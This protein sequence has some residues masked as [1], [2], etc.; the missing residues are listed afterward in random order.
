M[1]DFHILIAPNAFKNSLTAQ[2]AAKAIEKGFQRSALVCTTECFPIGDG[3]DGTGDLLIEKN[4]GQV[5]D[6]FVT[7][8]LGRKIKASYG[9]IDKG[10]T[11]V[12]E[13]AQASGL[14]LLET[15]EL[16]PLRATSFG[17]GQVISDALSNNVSKI[18]IAMGGSAT[19]DGGT[20]ILIALG[21]RFLDKNGV[22]LTAIENFNSLHTIDTSLIDPRALACEIIVLCDVDNRLLGA[23]GAAAM[24]GPQKGAGKE[25]VIKLENSLTRLTEIIK[26]TN[27]KNI[28][29][30]PY[31]GTAG[32][33]AAGLYALV[34]AQL[35]NGAES[36]LHFTGFEK[37]LAVSNLVITGEGSIDEQTL[38][39]KGPYAVAVMAKKKEVPVVGFA[40]R[41]PIGATE[42]LAIW[43]RE[44]LLINDSNT[45]LAAALLATAQNLERTAF[46]LGNVLAANRTA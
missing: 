21:A 29:D 33:A 1:P 13:M 42:K 32:G 22:A 41:I 18:L 19:V 27:G 9:L 44:L 26:S 45:D 24:F 38:Q 5:I 30:L 39:G 16:N 7:D 35:V 14:R 11:A 2:L 25:E 40:G 4:G 3:G 20:G 15:E 36:F 34:G 28:T 17:T 6:V 31:G 46:N 10:K 12:I 23:T 8:P 37:S 43:F